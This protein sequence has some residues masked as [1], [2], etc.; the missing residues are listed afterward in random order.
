MRIQYTVDLI[1]VSAWAGSDATAVLVETT[2]D[3]Q[4]HSGHHLHNHHNHTDNESGHFVQ[5]LLS[6]QHLIREQQPMILL[7]CQTSDS[8]SSSKF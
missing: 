2:D 5:I 4:Q 6:P 3:D 8:A 7:G 1:I